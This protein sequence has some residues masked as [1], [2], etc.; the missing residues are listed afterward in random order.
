M[1][2][3]EPKNYERMKRV[4]QERARQGLPNPYMDIART[5]I[6]GRYV[7]PDTNPVPMPK[8]FDKPQTEHYNRFHTDTDID[9]D[10]CI[11]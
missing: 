3:R 2:Q 1:R 8:T 4:Q 10:D 9:P 7:P 11:W 6:D 5:M